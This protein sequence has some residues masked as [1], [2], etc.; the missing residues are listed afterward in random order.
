MICTHNMESA[1]Y[2]NKHWLKQMIVQLSY[3]SLIAICGKL[4][5]YLTFLPSE[6][7]YFVV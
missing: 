3:I 5:N 6:N 1:I 2:E 7:L 4:E